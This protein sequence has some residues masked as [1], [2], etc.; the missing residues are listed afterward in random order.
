MNARTRQQNE[1]EGRKAEKHVAR[2]L[3]R[4]GW[5]ILDERYKTAEGEVDL[6]AKRGK[7]LAF[8][9]VKQRENMPTKD[10]LLT[11][12]NVERVMAAAEIWVN[13]HF[14]SLP[15]DFEIRFDLAVIKGSVGL[16]S[17]VS[18]IPNAFRG[19]W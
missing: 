6:I 13:R 4:R 5:T 10:D 17:K 7:I 14:S 15:Q 11:A 3:K 9:E 18:Y 12:S 8:I 16:L 2:Y 1:A 19:D